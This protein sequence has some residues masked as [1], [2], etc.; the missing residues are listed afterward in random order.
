MRSVSFNFNKMLKKVS[1]LPT[2]PMFRQ[3][4]G[5]SRAIPISPK[6][7]RSLTTRK[8]AVNHTLIM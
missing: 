8:E 6:A 3:V 1:S 5:K 7:V 2:S 4:A